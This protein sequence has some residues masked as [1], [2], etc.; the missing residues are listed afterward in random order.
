MKILSI[1]SEILTMNILLKFIHP[2]NPNKKKIY[3]V[4][5]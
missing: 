3:P 5:A 1:Y 2:S 4:L